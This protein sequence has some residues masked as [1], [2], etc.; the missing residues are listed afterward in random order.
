MIDPAAQLIRLRG[1]CPGAELWT[2]PGPSGGPLVYL[3]ELKVETAGAV[4]TIDGLLCPRA[5]DGYDTRMFYSE[6]LPVS[7]MRNWAPHVVMG[8]GWHAHSWSGI[9]ADQPWLDILA[10]HLETVK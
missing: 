10:S 8:R 6:Q 7:P 9:G 4:R 2:E 5:R 3:P 1:L